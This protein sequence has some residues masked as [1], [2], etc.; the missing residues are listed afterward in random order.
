MT[1]ASV[2][3]HGGGGTGSVAAGSQCE[4][5][6]AVWGRGALSNEEPPASQ[7]SRPRLGREELLAEASPPKDTDKN[8]QTKS[9]MEVTPM[10]G[11]LTGWDRPLQNIDPGL[12]M[13]LTTRLIWKLRE[14]GISCTPRV[15][16]RLTT[17]SHLILTSIPRGRA[18][19]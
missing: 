7:R 9:A 3:P 11:G 4:L 8:T 1:W 12:P 18:C 6:V 19:H 15:R 13:N 14:C 10:A 2:G 16:E 17:A 5:G